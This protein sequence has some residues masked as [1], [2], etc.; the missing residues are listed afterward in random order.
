MD[1]LVVLRGKVS[2]MQEVNC[3]ADLGIALLA[4]YHEL[5]TLMPVSEAIRPTQSTPG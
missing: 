5:V 4:G 1:V 2:F 3:M